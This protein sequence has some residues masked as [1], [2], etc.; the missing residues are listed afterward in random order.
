MYRRIALVFAV[1]ALFTLGASQAQAKTIQ[2]T[3]TV[4]GTLAVI[5]PGGPGGGCDESYSAQCPTIFGEGAS[6]TCFNTEA[7]KITGGLGKGDVH[8]DIT[9]DASDEVEDN[10]EHGC[11]PI[12]GEL[13]VQ[14]TSPKTRTTDF[15]D[16]Y[17]NGTACRHLTEK[18]LDIIEGGF[19][20]HNCAFPTGENKTT[21]SGYGEV[22]G[23]FDPGT[24]KVVL[25]LH[26]PITFPGEG[27]L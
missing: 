18:G 14:I 9:V 24:G 10:A 25:K 23:T 2:A 21:A 15:T 16:V 6:C 11:K 5:F 17:L 13:D 8:I 7:G 19:A 3:E 20:I 1:A 4:T 26:G 22:D 27:C 12:F